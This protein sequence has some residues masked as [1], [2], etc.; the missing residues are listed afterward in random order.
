MA[1]SFWDRTRGSETGGSSLGVPE[2][3][4]RFDAVDIG[5]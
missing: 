1:G 5:A 4:A 2:F 3:Q